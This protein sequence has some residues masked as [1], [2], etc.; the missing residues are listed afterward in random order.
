MPYIR[1]IKK[2]LEEALD[3][4]PVVLLIGAR[5]TGK[6]TLIKEIAQERGYS[7]YTFDN[8]SLFASAKKDPEGFILGLTKPAILD[9]VQRIPEIFLPIK[10]DLEDNR[11][12]GRYALTGSA[13][14]LLL[15]TLGDSLAGRMSIFELYP[16]SQGELVRIKEDFITLVYGD[17]QPATQKLS[18]KELIQKMMVG[19]FPPVQGATSSQRELWFDDYIRTILTREVTDLSRIE[20]LLELPQLMQLLAARAGTMLNVSDLLVKLT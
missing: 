12:A 18:K 15:P 13:N 7:Y 11:I 10:L 1:N 19:G 17:N 20:G 4:S 2:N 14:P 6:S 5:Q 9:E 8:L 16:L 3:F